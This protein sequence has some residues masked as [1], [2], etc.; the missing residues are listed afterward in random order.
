[1]ILG[2]EKGAYKD[3]RANPF[4]GEFDVEHDPKIIFIG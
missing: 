3:L 1:M 4:D 2:N